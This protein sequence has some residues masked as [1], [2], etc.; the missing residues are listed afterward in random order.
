MDFDHSEKVLGLREELTG[1]MDEH[2][3]PNERTYA[4]QLDEATARGERRSIPPVM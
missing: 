2:V 3:Y 4:E 1:F